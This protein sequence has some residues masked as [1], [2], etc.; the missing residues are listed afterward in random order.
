MAGN[1][2]TVASCFDELAEALQ[3]SAAVLDLPSRPIWQIIRDQLPKAA[4]VD[5]PR[6]PRIGLWDGQDLA[7]SHRHHSH[8]AG[9][10]PFDVFDPADPQWQLVLQNSIS[11][12]IGHGPGHWSG[13]CVPWAAMLHLRFG[14]ADM[15]EML[16]ESFER[17][18]TNEGHGT[19]HNG[20]IS[21][22]TLMGVGPV[23][24]RPA[25]EHEIMQMDAGMSSVAAILEMLLHTQ[26]GVNHLFAG[27]PAAWGA[28]S[29]NGIL[30]EGAFLVDA[31][32]L[33]DG[34]VAHV[35]VTSRAAAV[36]RLANPW[37]GEAVRCT[38]VSGGRSRTLRGAVLEM[39]LR[40]GARVRLTAHRV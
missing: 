17:V 15:A 18:F 29:F 10:T 25:D 40:P 24:G 28:V 7:E 4:L 31:A 27:A 2:P 26:R 21:G 9:I 38:P 30:T 14:N 11:H 37:A 13:W 1:R 16:L 19:R 33:A 39:A 3:E 23:G 36:F 32:R 20:V 35:V 5:D 6:S 8:L 34:R 12:W 22:W